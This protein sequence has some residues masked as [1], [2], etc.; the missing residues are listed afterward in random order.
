MRFLSKPQVVC[1]ALMIPPLG[2]F[3]TVANMLSLARVVLAIPVTYLILIDGSV[4]WILGLILL[5]GLTDWFDGN[6]ARWSHTVSNWG[7]VLDPLSDKT[8]MLMVSVALVIRGDLPIWFVGII[9]LRE[10]LIVVGSVLLTR[11]ISE[12]KMS[13][14]WGKVAIT[15]MA[16]TVL[17]AL[18]KADPP[19]LQ[20]C[21]W[22]TLALMLYSFTLYN[23]RYL[24]LWRTGREAPADKEAGGDSGS[25]VASLKQQTG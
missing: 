14:W 23:L 7:K 19:V 4:G 13:M 24:R 3:W 10:M 12:V 17:A 11:R 22:L 18:L 25:T 21:I 2:Q 6:L 8:A 20:F 15:A 9:A 16:V 5:A 1:G